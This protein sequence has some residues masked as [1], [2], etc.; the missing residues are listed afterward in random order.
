MS[1]LDGPAQCSSP[2]HPPPPG[3]PYVETDGGSVAG[4][5]SERETRGRTRRWLAVGRACMD[6]I[7]GGTERVEPRSGSV[8]ERERSRGSSRKSPSHLLPSAHRF[9]NEPLHLEA[10]A[11]M[12]RERGVSPR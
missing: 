11:T 8:A 6:L 2:S 12:T 9:I 7:S 10:V 3:S 5:D 4:G 1:S